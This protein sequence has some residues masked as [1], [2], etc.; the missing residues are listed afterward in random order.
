MLEKKQIPIRIALK[1]VAMAK[2]QL[3]G[4]ASKGLIILVA[5]LTA[6]AL[7]LVLSSC[8]DADDTDIEGEGQTQ[9]ETVQE[10]DA[11]DEA[12][13]QDPVDLEAA[14]NDAF[15]DYILDIALQ[16]APTENLLW[17]TDGNVEAARVTA[18]EIEANAESYK[19]IIKANLANDAVIFGI[20]EENGARIY[21]FSPDG[22]L[23]ILGMGTHMGIGFPSTMEITG[24][25]QIDGI[26]KSTF[27][28]A[29]NS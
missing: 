27:T 28:Y 17:S 21:T 4:K 13:N 1:G 23:N 22:V 29:M 25:D 12:D 11:D 2:K 9:E 18:G 8:D 19:E 15:A 24:R 7:A 3:F 14:A 5:I 26:W 10:E 6:L 20:S 16:M